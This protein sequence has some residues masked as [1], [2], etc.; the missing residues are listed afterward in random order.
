MARLLLFTPITPL[1]RRAAARLIATSAL[2]ALAL[3]ATSTL[4]GAASSK[5]PSATISAHL[6][7]TSFTSA[8][9]KKIKLI[10]KFS[11]PSKS[12]SCLLT[13]K[14]G[15]KWQTIKSV[16][17]SGTFRGT[18]SMTV[19]KVFA[20]KPVKVGSYRLKLSADG[21]SKR[22]SFK[23]KPT[24]PILSKPANTAPPTISGATTQ[25]Q[26]L[27][28]SNG[29][30]S[31]S[32]ASYGYKW[33]RCN[34]S[35]SGCADISGATASPY[36]LVLADVASTI[37][38]VVTAKNASGSSSAT[39]SQTV[40]VSGLPPANTS[41]PTISG[42]PGQSQTLSAS[43]GSWTNS[44][45]SYAYQWRRCDNSGASCADIATATTNTHL[46]VLADVG[47]TIRVV[48]T[49]TN[50]YGDSGPATSSQ[51][52]V[53]GVAPAN[54]ALPTISGTTTQGQTLTAAN[55]SW[56]NVP[57]SFAYQWRRCDSSGANCTSISGASASTYTLVL[58]DVGSTIRAVVTASNTSG[59]SSPAT[60]SQ[61]AVVA[62]LPPANTALPTISGATTV[63]LTLTASN[64]SWA[65]TP[66]SSYAYQ[67][68]RCDNFGASCV[69]I[70][71]AI[72]NTYVLVSGDGGFTIR[73]VVIATNAYGASNPATSSQTA[74][75]ED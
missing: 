11:V 58:A 73:V 65:N 4:A 9:V 38:V 6:T 63:G 16:N 49:A 69:D 26:T 10:Y 19:K 75:V 44:P 62:G 37:R 17:K 33:R 14:K 29:S 3:V 53:V 74:L 47:S 71:S 45:T 68:R 7:K 15:S 34:A 46:L 32:P 22:L 48:V 56:D 50:T 54:T 36:T 8:Q 35:G 13:R 52:L 64:G 23:V 72:S 67:W 61:T 24:A 30:W 60:S 70:S 66:P 21:G 39:S 55:G 42:T 51:T 43:N 59:S 12:F 40:V 57:T 41:L 1:G 25:G 18:K 27:T 28:A 2:C 20:K 5:A 31:N